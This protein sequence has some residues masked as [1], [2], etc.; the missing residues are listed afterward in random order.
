MP[1]LD[2]YV[3]ARIREIFTCDLAEA[4]GS[5][6]VEVDNPDVAAAIPLG[7][8][9]AEGAMIQAWRAYLDEMPEV[10]NG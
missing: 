9:R 10:H 8:I 3:E 5:G 4:V 2:E 1:T 6:R 7:L